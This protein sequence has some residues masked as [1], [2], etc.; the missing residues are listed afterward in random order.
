MKSII[1]YIKEM[2]VLL[3]LDCFD[4]RKYFDSES[5]KDAM[6]AL[7]C[8]RVRGKLYNLIYELNKSSTIQI[9]TSVGV[10]DSFEV[11]PTVA[12]GSIGGGLISSCNLD[13]SV[14]RYFYNSSTEV[15]YH[16]LKM[17]PLIYQDDL[18]RF[19][20]SEKQL[21]MEPRR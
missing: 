8:Y 19:A 5:L 4:L 6:N 17:Q 3:V 21:E 18:G 12:Q 15:F 11:G 20:A 7:Y 14:N 2:G 16:D 9:Q 10:S 1:S 13:Y